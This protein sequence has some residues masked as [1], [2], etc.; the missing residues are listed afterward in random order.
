MNKSILNIDLRS[1]IIGF[2]LAAIAFLIFK[3]FPS[4]AQTENP[5][6]SISAT[7]DGVYIINRTT[8]YTV[9]REKRECQKPGVCTYF[10]K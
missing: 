8:S 3:G 2:L 6:Y 4:Q 10:N 9:F 7:E 1:L 5:E